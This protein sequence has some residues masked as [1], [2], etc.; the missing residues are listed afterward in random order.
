MARSTPRPAPAST[1]ADVARQAGVSVS[2]VSH[3][4]NGTRKVSPETVR[5]VEEA[6]ARTAYIPNTLA[7]SLAGA[8][9]QSIGIA[10]SAISNHY[11]SEVVGGIEVEAKRHGLMIF[12]SDTHDDPAQE[13]QTVQALHQRRVD[14]IILAASADPDRTALQYLR[15]HA[16]PTVL[17]D[18]L[19]APDFDQV[20]VENRRS[21]IQ[22]VAHLASHGHRRIAL[23]AGQ[24][25]LS[26]SQ[27]R[28]AGYK[29][30]LKQAGL[31]FDPALV[32]TGHSALEPARQAVRGLLALDPRPDA[33]VAGNNLMTI[34]AMHALRDAGLRVPGDIA[35]AG[36]DDFDWATAFSPRLTVVAQPCAELGATAVRLL[37]RRL[38]EPAAKPKTVRLAATLRVRD[39]CGC[40]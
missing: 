11:F 32:V 6:I 18:R 27:E 3:V 34:G 35:L 33:V 16:I 2:T 19:V 17:I 7:R 36:F 39:S 9:T 40:A 23:V 28:L 29:A 13:L 37:T 31:G 24:P 30:G 12:L 1:M 10:L 21:T 22:L 5:A 25:G 20:G 4:L 8:T 15:T 26:T 38:Q 14:G